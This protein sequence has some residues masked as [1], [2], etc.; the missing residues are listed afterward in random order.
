MKKMLMLIVAAALASCSSAG[1]RT[2][3]LESGLAFFEKADGPGTMPCAGVGATFQD[4]LP[5]RATPVTGWVGDLGIRLSAI[6]DDL[7]GAKLTGD[8]EELDVGTRFYAYSGSDTV[9]PYFGFGG[10]LSRLHLDDGDVGSSDTVTP[11]LYGI[12][13]VDL[14]FGKFRLG[15]AYRHTAGVDARLEGDEETSNLDGGE[16]LV[17]VGVSL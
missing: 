1:F 17:S 3:R 10:V 12:L 2:S 6:S 15:I 9:Q 5:P 16:A 7:G 8:R 13:G 11:G 14:V 4:D